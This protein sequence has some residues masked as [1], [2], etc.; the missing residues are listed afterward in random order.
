MGDGQGTGAGQ[1]PWG[2]YSHQA[3]YIAPSL[4]RPPFREGIKAAA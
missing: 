3:G 4:A 1:S 2:G